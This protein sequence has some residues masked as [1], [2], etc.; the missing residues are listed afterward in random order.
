MIYFDKVENDN[1]IK[2][3]RLDLDY[4]EYDL[5]L[6]MLNELKLEK[7]DFECIIESKKKIN[8]A[9]NLLSIST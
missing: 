8:N 3:Y 7:S 9:I 5:M 4:H 1:N 6:S 2:H